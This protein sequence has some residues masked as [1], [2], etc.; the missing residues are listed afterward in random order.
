MIRLLIATRLI[1]ALTLC[2]L[3]ALAQTPPAAANHPADSAESLKQQAL[4]LNRDLLILEEELLFPANSQMALYL[5]MDVGH[6]FQLDSVKVKLDDTFI[7]SE[8]Y[9]AKQVDTLH[10]GGIQKLYLGNVRQG[11]HEI[12]AFFTGIGPEGQAYKRAASLTVEKTT[13]PLVLELKIVDSGQKLQPVFNIKQ[14]EL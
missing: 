2:A 1:L 8:L 7:A 3:P 5:S 11:E 4:Q 6:Y 12:S 13:A 10:R 14:W 9:T